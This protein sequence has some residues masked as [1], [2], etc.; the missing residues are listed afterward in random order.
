MQSSYKMAIGGQGAKIAARSA[1][2]RPFNAAIAGKQVSRPH[3]S[4]V[5][6]ISVANI[7]DSTSKTVSPGLFEIRYSN[8]SKRN[9]SSMASL[10]AAETIYRQLLCHI[11]VASKI[12]R[13]LWDGTL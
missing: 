8:F 5:Y 3:M 1:L 7:D 9:H 4:A 2:K 11:P 10:H 13:A 6:Q 12:R